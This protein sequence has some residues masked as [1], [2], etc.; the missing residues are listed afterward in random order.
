[1]AHPDSL[2]DLFKPALWL[3]LASFLVGFAGMLALAGPPTMT[4]SAERAELA[5]AMGVAGPPLGDS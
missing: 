5:A 2:F 3:V 4:A 1:M